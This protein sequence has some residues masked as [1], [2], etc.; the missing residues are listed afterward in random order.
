MEAP[1]GKDLPVRRVCAALKVGDAKCQFRVS[2]GVA[3]A[4]RRA[5]KSKYTRLLTLGLFRV[6]N[7]KLPEPL[8]SS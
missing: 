5:C 2:D 8:R 1:E 6:L 7:P 3:V 4:N